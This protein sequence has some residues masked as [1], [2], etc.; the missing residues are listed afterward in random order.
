VR[1]RLDIFE[2]TDPDDAAATAIV[3]AV[4]AHRHVRA[5]VREI[6]PASPVALAER[7]SPVGLAERASP[8]GLVGPARRP[9]GRPCFGRQ[10]RSVFGVRPDADLRRP[11]A[12]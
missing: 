9:V 4:L 12:A 8:V 1:A 7:A 11:S 3:D 5:V 10:T 6:E 2:M